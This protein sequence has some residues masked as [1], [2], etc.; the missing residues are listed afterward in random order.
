VRSNGSVPG[1]MVHGGPA[2]GVL[3]PIVG[4]AAGGVGD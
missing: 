2:V 3:A 4:V 1:V